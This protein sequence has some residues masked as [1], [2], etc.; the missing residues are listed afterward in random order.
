VL[1]FGSISATVNVLGK[2]RGAVGR[3]LFLVPV[4]N[5]TTSKKIKDSLQRAIGRTI[6]CGLISTRRNLDAYLYVPGLGVQTILITMLKVARI[7]LNELRRCGVSSSDTLINSN[8]N[9]RLVRT[10]DIHIASC[11]WRYGNTDIVVKNTDFS[12]REECNQILS[13]DSYCP[14]LF[15]VAVKGLV[16]L[17]PLGVIIKRGQKDVY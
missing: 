16:R 10:K 9:S 8:T 6:V 1:T 17:Q 5:Y 11:P 2:T 15:H 13:K 4:L 7:N 3:I 14:I 12:L